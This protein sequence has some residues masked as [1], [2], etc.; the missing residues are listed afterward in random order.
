MSS[1]DD[2][3]TV[4]E[5]FRLAGAVYVIK[6][7]LKCAADGTCPQGMKCKNGECVSTGLSLG[8]VLLIIFLSSLAI[9]VIGGIY[10]WWSNRR[11]MAAEAA[12]ASVTLP[13]GTT[14]PAG[15]TRMATSSSPFVRT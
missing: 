7:P 3:P 15:A 13:A 9:L 4:D 8:S 11:K 14:V 1:I 5:Q 6:E 2:W 12:A 10:E